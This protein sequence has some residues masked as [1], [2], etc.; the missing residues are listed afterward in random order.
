MDS[1]ALLVIVCQSWS[2]ARQGDF[3]TKEH[4]KTISESTIVFVNNYAFGPEV[5][6]M[7]KE[8]SVSLS[9]TIDNIFFRFLFLR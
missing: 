5:D 9:F 2:Y 3:L 1:T 8:R 6:H 4:R 7:L